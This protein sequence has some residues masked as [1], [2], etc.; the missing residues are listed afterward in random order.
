MEKSKDL[1]LSYGSELSG[2]LDISLYS[3]I[4]NLLDLITHKQ[5]EGRRIFI[6]GNGGSGANANHIENDFIYGIRNKK[7]PYGINIE[8]LN[9]NNSV[10]TCLA[11]DVGYS[12]IFTEQIKNKANKEDL[13]IVLSGSGNSKNIISAL[14]YTNTNNID[15]FAILG[16]D[17]GQALKLSKSSIHIKSN[18]MQIVEDIQ[19]IIFHFMTNILK[20]R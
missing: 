11:N 20:H 12:E 4:L 7:Y 5:N 16:F 1:F 18:S 10:I 13:L 15:N 9:S 8:S 2:L 17:G 19:M 3:K 6:C 14:K